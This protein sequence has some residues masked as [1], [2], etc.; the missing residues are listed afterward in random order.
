MTVEMLQRKRLHT[1]I[2]KSAMSKINLLFTQRSI[3]AIP[4]IYCQK[5]TQKKESVCTEHM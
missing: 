2:K 3:L 4:F 1:I 5:L